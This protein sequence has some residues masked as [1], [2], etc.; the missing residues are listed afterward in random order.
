MD[1]TLLFPY[2]KL[3][4]SVVLGQRRTN[5]RWVSLFR[6]TD[7]QRSFEERVKDIFN[8]WGCVPS[9][10]QYLRITTEM[11]EAEGN[12]SEPLAIPPPPPVE[13]ASPKKTTARKKE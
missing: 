6:D 5:P 11:L 8:T 4:D 13:L 7:S 1:E 9:P 12:N 3:V 10:S 2:E